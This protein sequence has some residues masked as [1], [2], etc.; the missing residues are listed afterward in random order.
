MQ[1]DNA[2]KKK[3]SRKCSVE[4]KYF[5]LS[6][7]NVSQESPFAIHINKQKKLLLFSMENL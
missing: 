1:K 4:N 6:K 7:P 5:Q 3:K 2:I